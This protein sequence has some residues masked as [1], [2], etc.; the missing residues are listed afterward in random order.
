MQVHCAS[1]EE[2]SGIKPLEEREFISK[3]TVKK[4]LGWTDGSIKKFLGEP[5]KLARNPNYLTGPPMQLYRQSRV[6][7]TMELEEWKDWYQRTLERRQSQSKKAKEVADLKRN[8]AIFS[9]LNKLKIKFPKAKTK[10]DIYRR[11]RERWARTKEQLSSERG[12]Y[13]WFAVPGPDVDAATQRRWLNNWIR[14]D[15][16]NYEQILY[17]LSGQ[18]GIN[19][20]HD[21]LQA[22]IEARTELWFS[23]FP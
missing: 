16:S 11:T 5:D 15:C 7:E 13:E 20:A 17:E 9:A 3:S 1:N 14:H 23:S 22:E 6:R 4:E 10:Q 21:R 18:V 12:E 2:K 8:K 19:D